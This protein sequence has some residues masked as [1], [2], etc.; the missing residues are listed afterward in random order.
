MRLPMRSLLRLLLCVAFVVTPARVSAQLINELY[1]NNATSTLAT[2]IS[3]VATSITVAS[4][5]GA[6]FPSPTGS[7]YMWITIVQN[8]TVEV[9]KCTAR[10]TDVISGC[11][12]AQQSTTASVFPSGATVML[13]P[14]AGTMN[15]IRALTAI[16]FVTTSAT[17]ELSAEVTTV[18]VANGGTGVATLTGLPLGSGTSAFSA[19]T[20][21]TVGQP[22]RVTASDTFGFGALDLADTDAVTGVLPAVNFAT[23]TPTGS[24]FL[25]DDQVWTTISGGGDA[26][27]GNPLS[28]FASTTSAQFAGVIS[29]ATGSGAVVLGTNPVLTTPN[30]GTPS[31]GVL[32]NA[33]GLPLTTGV[34]GRLF[35]SNVVQGSALSVIGVVRSEERR[36]GKECRSRWSPYH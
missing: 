9:L 6:R 32:T 34:T 35:F 1:S 13:A 25:R 20:S 26:L 7:Q 12:R 14:T 17:S 28:Q 4:G 2:A 36:V 5:H 22:L 30:L 3:A 11:T 18:P 31:A 24:K 29:D 27:V 21:S 10:A 8:T 19:I 16:P 33:T 15:N 23:G